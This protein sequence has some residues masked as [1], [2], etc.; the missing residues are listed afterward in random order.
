MKHLAAKRSA[1]DLESWTQPGVV[2]Y[3][4]IYLLLLSYDVGFVSLAILRE[5]IDRQLLA[6]KRQSFE[7]ST[8]AFYLVTY[9][10]KAQQQYD[11]LPLKM[12]LFLEKLDPSESLESY[13]FI[14]QMAEEAVGRL[15]AGAGPK[16]G[17]VTLFDMLMKIYPDDYKSA[18]MQNYWWPSA[19]MHGHQIGMLD[20]LARFGDG[21]IWFSHDSM[22]STRTRN[23]LVITQ[24]LLNVLLLTG[25]RFDLR[26][27]HWVPLVERFNAIVR[28]FHPDSK[29]VDLPLNGDALRKAAQHRSPLE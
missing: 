17:E 14:M 28:R 26:G 13:A 5:G 1:S 7:Y 24:S 19:V 29:I 27:A 8:R 9:P 15:P 11:A 21:K 25:D 16:Y 10:E 12:R 6:M 20:A 4:L 18:Y 23:V 2:G 3:W 22:T